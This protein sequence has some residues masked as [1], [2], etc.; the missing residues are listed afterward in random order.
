M[1]HNLKETRA[2]GQAYRA[3][4]LMK[5]NLGAFAEPTNEGS[6]FH[7]NIDFQVSTTRHSCDFP[8]ALTCNFFSDMLSPTVMYCLEM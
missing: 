8:G 3:Y 4:W 5:E 6:I 7:G 2:G 1:E